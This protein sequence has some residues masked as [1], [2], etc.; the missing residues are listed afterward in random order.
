MNK[1]EQLYSKSRTAPRI[2][3]DLNDK[4]AKKLWIKK[5]DL[6]CHVAYTSIKTVTT[7]DWYFDKGCSRH[8]TGDKRDLS[9][10]QSMLDRHVFFGDGGK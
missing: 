7:N 9:D 3:I 1:I 6:F 5:S 2:K 10:Y 4:P 8:M